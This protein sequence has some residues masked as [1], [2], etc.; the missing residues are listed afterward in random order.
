MLVSFVSAV[1]ASLLVVAPPAPP[2]RGTV[3]ALYRAPAC[4]RC[5]GHRG[6]TVATADRSEVRAVQAGRVTFV[7]QVARLTYVV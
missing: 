7:G 4:A 5:T 2:V 1:V 3:I 6:V